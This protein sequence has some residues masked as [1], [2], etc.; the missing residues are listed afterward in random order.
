MGVAM[1]TITSKDIREHLSDVLNK[2]AYKDQKYIITRS[3]KDVA[4]ILS[5]E[6]WGLIEKMMQ[7]MEDEEDVRDADQA[8]ARYIKEGAIPFDQ[9]MKELGL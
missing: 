6:E 7:K 9:A 4:V 2:V 1:E 3:G 5:M 8:H